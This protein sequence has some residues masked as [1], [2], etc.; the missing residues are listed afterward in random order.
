MV[1]FVDKRDGKVTTAATERYVEEFQQSQWVGKVNDVERCDEK[2]G[3]VAIMGLS[4]HVTDVSLGLG[5][6]MRDLEFAA[7]C[8]ILHRGGVTAKGPEQLKKR[9]D[10]FSGDFSARHREIMIFGHDVSYCLVI[11][12]RLGGVFTGLLLSVNL[13]IAVHCPP[14]MS[15]PQVF[16]RLSKKAFFI[17]LPHFPSLSIISLLRKSTARSAAR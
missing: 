17:P 12:A 14:R 2:R 16:Q 15:P 8:M 9:G 11:G 6:E 10:D 4:A 13:M 1:D 7:E 5:R 3:D